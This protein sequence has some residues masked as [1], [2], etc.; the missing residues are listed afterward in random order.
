VEG[1]EPMR[2]ETAGRTSGTDYR[3][4]FDAVNDAILIHEV[5]TGDIVDLNRGMCEMFGYS[6]ES[7]GRL[8]IAD[9]CGG[10]SRGARETLRR[11]IEKTA[12][13]E[14]QP[15]EW[16]AKTSSG[17]FFWAEVHLKRAVLDGIER[18]LAVIRDISQRKRAEEALKES[19]AR[20][21]LVT[22][23][24]LAGVYIIQDRK[25]AYCNSTMAQ[26]FGYGVEEILDGKV[27]PQDL[28]HPDDLPMVRENIRKRLA[29]EEE[30]VHYTFRGRRRDGTVIYCE[31]LG[32]TIVYQGRPALIGTLMDISGRVQAEEALRQ[33]EQRYR[34]IVEVQTELV[35][36]HL[37][38][39][40]VTF[41]NEAL[42]RYFGKPRDELLGGSFLSSIP[43]ED[44]SR[45]MEAIAGLSRDN[46]MA[47]LEQRVINAD[48]E[49]RWQQWTNQVLFDDQ[50]HILEHQAVGRDITARRQAEE[51]LRAQKNLLD[52]VFSATPDLLALKDRDF[53]YQAVNPAFCQFLGQTAEE[54][55]GQTDFE[56]FPRSEAEKY[57]RDDERVLTEGAAL[58]LDEEV[59]G[60]GG[61]KWLQVIKTPVVDEPG[62]PRGILC[63]V[64]DISMRKRA[65]E[66]LKESEERYRSL[67]Q[68]NHAVMLL[69]D[70]ETAAIV[71]ANPA[72]CCFYGYT[73]EQLTA[74]K[75][76]DINLLPKEQ[77]FGEMARARE[78]RQHH[79]FFRH[80][81]ANG[82]V[83]EVEVFSG[84]IR[85]R[86]RKLLYSI[87]HDVTARKKAEE[88]LRASEA[89]YRTL[90]EQI[91]AVTYMAALDNFT[92]HIYISPQIEAVL[93]FS[94]E[95]WL[96]NPESFKNQIHPEDRDRVLSELILS[97]S[98]GGPFVS[99]YRLLAKSGR[100][101]WVRD[102]SRAVYDVDGLPLF[103]HGVA[104]DITAGKEAEEALRDASSKLQA[105]VQA[106]PLAIVALDA[107]AKV[108]SWNPAAERIFGWHRDE[109]L[110]RPHPI[111]PEEK[112]REFRTIYQRV[113]RGETIRGLELRRQRRDGSPVDISL[114]VAPLYDAA[115]KV[116]GVMGVMEDITVRKR[117]EEELRRQ[118]ELLDLAQ[119]AILVRDLDNRIT[120]WNRGATETY[121]W[122]GTEALGQVTHELLQTEF[123]QSL[124][125]VEAE[126]LQQ[127]QW[128]GEMGHTKRQGQRIVVA[129]R[130]ALRR[131]RQ[132]RPAAILEINRDITPRRRMEEALQRVSRALKAI[133]ECHQAMMR[134][135]SETELLNEVCRIIVEVG[136]YLM[137][138]VG[139]AQ[140]DE[141]KTV[142]P[143]AQM[144]FDAGYVHVIRVR[145]SDTELG[146]GPV[147]EAIRRGEPAIC[148]DTLTDPGFAPWRAEALKRGYASM[149][150]L[151]LKDSQT[152]GALSI[153]AAEPNPFDHEEI[154]LLIG[155]ANDLAYGITALR[156]NAERQRA[157]E[158]L[159]ESEEKYRGLMDYSSDA[160]LLGDLEG[161]LTEANRRAEE[162]L[163]Y[164]KEELLKMRYTQLHPPETLEAIGRTFNEIISTGSGQINETAVLRKDGTQVAVDITGSVIEYAGKKVAQGIFR[165]ITARRKAEEALRE[166]E[167]KLRLLTSQLLTIQER[168]R[169]RVSRELHD[170]LGQALTVLKIH[171]VAIENKLRRDQQGLKA[172]CDQLLTYIDGVIENV[173]RLSWDLSPS[174]L[175]D[176]G[177]SSSLGYL[178][179]E[180]C[181]NN[182]LRCS[183]AM[184]DIDQLFSAETRINIYRIFQESLT[185]I[186]KHARATQISVGISREGDAVSFTI[187]DNGRGFDQKKVMAREMAKRGLGLTAMNE[188]ALMARGSLSIWSQ[189]DQGTRIRF[190]IPIDR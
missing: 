154:N 156:A 52:T 95:E 143:V 145:W 128:Q 175:E 57:R 151:P 44:R 171:L 74:K 28:V 9:L 30:S 157:E 135:A 80:R 165:D 129:S 185:N 75:I 150:A 173:R 186:V 153:Y 180:T 170:E 148:R 85:V 98:Q 58:V 20:F 7:A 82:K 56:L 158:A 43:E 54:I 181:R 40:T 88:A 100:V 46:P 117:A 113:L 159:R 168:E 123:S 16:R 174:I 66:G 176:L 172:N 31:V 89:K 8:N 131:D 79:F 126:L 12:G 119:D 51:A 10:D 90:V 24:S 146:R 53:V 60:A 138:W 5:E 41:V 61:K 91:P 97:Y 112:K 166:S 162:L 39:T 103:M 55:V 189:K 118:A 81:L 3:A 141:D 183:L 29:G 177:L 152:F 124:S 102:E 63:S 110:G 77:I 136:G 83:R 67:F 86:G 14:M 17:Q 49:I 25:F 36:R 64:T 76:T 122:T 101:V 104:M 62:A 26:I 65:E 182:N 50:G 42:C 92:T 147:G 6:R 73:R 130:W 116:G 13:G 18:V 132:G 139:F 179:D 188:R 109:V 19:E 48:G 169:R 125:E 68:N 167:L 27:A 160:I 163:G 105:L 127:G 84:P 190:L 69:I 2:E 72:A 178:I 107:D 45:L 34:A 149:L 120:F 47:V 161:H 99:E 133:T 23:G 4:I 96:A 87:I 59:T 21:R 37:P 71:D 1:R 121:G 33:S 134:A 137:A 111:V 142:R 106:S 144:G 35:C 94:Q 22:E 32:S 187:K 108:I 70:P 115:G 164:T 93:D 15:F 38:D 184:D 155:L 114:S 78:R 140:Q 11:L